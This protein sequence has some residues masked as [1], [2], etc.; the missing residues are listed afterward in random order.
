MFNKIKNAI[1]YFTLST[2]L[3]C[4]TIYRNHGYAPSDEVLSNILIGIDTRASVEDTLGMPTI[5]GVPRTNSVTEDILKNSY[6]TKYPGGS[7]EVEYKASHILV[8]TEQKA[9]D[10]LS[11]LDGGTDF[12]GLAI[13]HSTGPSGPSGGDLG[14]FGKGQMVAPFES[15]VIGMEIG[16][17]TGPVKTQFGY[18]LIFL[19]NRRETSPPSFEDV[20]GEIEVEIQNKGESIYF[21]SS[22]WSHY[23]LKTPEPISRQIV[24]IQFDETGI[25]SNV[26]RYELSDSKVVVLSRRVTAGGASEISFI[27]QIMGNVGRLDARDILVAPQ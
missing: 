9:R 26:S 11:L 25:L 21:V 2:A 27:R 20:R 6:A 1:L 23:G 12:G 24:A 5:G 17:Y 10:L 22:R 16:T 3:S 18:H 19:N 15:A 8:E 4:T 13:E 14:W 7:G